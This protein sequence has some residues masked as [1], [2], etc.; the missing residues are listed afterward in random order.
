MNLTTADFA[1]AI[2]SSMGCSPKRWCGSRCW[3]VLSKGWFTA[4]N[5]LLRV[6][7]VSN[8][9]ML[10]HQQIDE[11]LNFLFSNFTQGGLVS[12]WASILQSPR[13]WGRWGFSLLKTSTLILLG[14]TLWDSHKPISWHQVGLQLAAKACFDV[15]EAPA[16]W[17]LM[18]LIAEVDL[19]GEI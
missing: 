6:D 13:N 16:F 9:L 8:H 19:T 1:C 7:C 2:C 14:L 3:L 17:G 12:L 11:F 5:R 15:R 18:E 4:F 10:S